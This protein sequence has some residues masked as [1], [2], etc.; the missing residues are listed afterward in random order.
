MVDRI[1]AVC[2]SRGKAAAAWKLGGGDSKDITVRIKS[3]KLM[4]SLMQKEDRVVTLH[5]NNIKN[6]NKTWCFFLFLVEIYVSLM[7]EFGL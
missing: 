4:I 5:S 7:P 1:G 6:F 2:W 3:E